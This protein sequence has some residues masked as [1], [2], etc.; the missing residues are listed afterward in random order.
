MQGELII[1]TLY[2]KFGIIQRMADKPIYWMG[3]SKSDLSSFPEAVRRNAG[4]QLRA[5]QRG[6]MPS[7]FKPISVVGRGVEE[8]RL[9]S[10]DGAYWIF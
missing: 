7:D 3:S 8:I 6:L 10:E 2:A 4:F 9:R 5:L 1:V